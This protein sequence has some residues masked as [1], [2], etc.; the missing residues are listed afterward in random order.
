MVH[1]IH[2]A[3]QQIQQ[4]LSKHLDPA[5]IVKL[6]RTARYHWRQRVLDPVSTIHLFVLQIL[7]GNPGA[8]GFPLAALGQ[9]T[10]HGLGVLPG[11]RA[12]AVEDFSKVIEKCGSGSGSGHGPG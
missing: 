12:V 11:A 10:V 9:E 8:P 5:A 7:N 2:E 1:R 3:L 4:D 6:C